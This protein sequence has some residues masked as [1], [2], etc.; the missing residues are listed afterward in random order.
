MK[1]HVIKVASSGGDLGLHI[2][3][4][5]VADDSGRLDLGRADDWVTI[6]CIVYNR[7]NRRFVGYAR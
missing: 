3:E 2:M 7:A 6:R 4:T 5:E 1:D